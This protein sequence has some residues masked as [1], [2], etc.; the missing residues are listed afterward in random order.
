MEKTCATQRVSTKRARKPNPPPEIGRHFIAM[1]VRDGADMAIAV[2][3]GGKFL[4]PVVWDGDTATM[5]PTSA[6]AG[7]DRV[8]G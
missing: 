3:S 5:Y 8:Q 1:S 7:Q 6:V 4:T 2:G